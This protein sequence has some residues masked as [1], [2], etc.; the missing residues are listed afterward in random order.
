MKK[1]VTNR[2]IDLDRWLGLGGLF[3]P[4]PVTDREV[5]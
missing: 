2:R 4:H 1:R 3:T 5:I